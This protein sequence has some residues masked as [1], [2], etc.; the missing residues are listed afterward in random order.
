MR[1]RQKTGS[2]ICPYCGKLVGAQEKECWNCGRKNPGLWGFA[3]LVRGLSNK[4][5]FV[6]I[7]IYGCAILYVATLLVDPQGIRMQGIFSILSPSSQSLLAFGASGWIPVFALDRW[8]T[9]LSAAWLHGGL[10]HIL[11]NMLWIR[12]LAPATA[13]L[14]GA[15]R[16]VIIYTVSSITGFLL[17]SG[18]FLILGE[19]QLLFIRSAPLTVGA[20]APIFGLLGALLVYG[21]RSGS[22]HIGSQAMMYAIILFVF[23]LIMPY[24]DNLAHLGGFLGGYAV[25]HLM[26]PLAKERFEHMIAAIACIAITLLSILASI[27]SSGVLFR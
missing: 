10:L 5:E 16:L 3:P 1:G 14:Y 15:P 25:A 9:V 2:I 19:S 20:S 17:T 22:K 7:V 26:N 6:P 23:G 13:E 11:F 21:Q 8:W 18:V 27:L 24:V 4:L 12:Q